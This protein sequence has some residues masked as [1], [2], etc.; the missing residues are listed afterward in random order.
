VLKR[1]LQFAETGVL[2]EATPTAADFDS[3]FEAN[4]AA[5]IESL[6]YRVETQVGSAGFRIDLAVRDPAKPG[7]FMLAIECDGATYHSALWARERDRLRQEVLEGLG[8]RIHRIWSTDWFYRRDEQM[9]KPKAALEAAR[10]DIERPGPIPASTQRNAAAKR[11]LGHGGAKRTPKRPKNRRRGKK[12]E[13]LSNSVKSGSIRSEKPSDAPRLQPY[14]LSECEAARGEKIEE[15]SAQR[16][17]G[18]VQAIIEQE[19]PIRQDEIMRRVESSFG[20]CRPSRR[21]ATIIAGALD[22]LAAKAPELRC[23]EGFWFSHRQNSAPPVRC[24][25][26]APARLRKPDMIAA[27]EIRAAIA[28]ARMHSR[29]GAT[30]LADAVAQ[31]FGLPRATPEMR[32]RILFCAKQEPL[33]PMALGEDRAPSGSAQTGAPPFRSRI[34]T[35]PSSPARRR[36]RSSG[37]PRECPRPS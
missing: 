21:A 1:F 7:R 19:G 2:E 26:G 16:L 22:V 37:R 33:P 14:A 28:L 32:S 12:K 3:P 18:M 5:A 36:E 34:K 15:I 10:G 35:P 8:W 30:D 27:I 24:R 20:R 23:E 31:L 11:R 9:R 6:G 13:S 25:T 17:A 29:P 4:V